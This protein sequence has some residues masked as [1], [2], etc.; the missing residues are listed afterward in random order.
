MYWTKMIS[1]LVA[2]ISAFAQSR[3]IEGIKGVASTNHVPEFTDTTVCQLESSPDQFDHK[4]IRVK[5]YF[6]FGLEEAGMYDPSCKQA[7][8]AN[9]D[10]RAVWVEFASGAEHERV[11]GYRPLIEDQELQKFH[12]VEEQRDGQ[13]L[14]AVVTGTFYAAK[15]AKDRKPGDVLFFAGYGHMNC[16]HLFV[17]SQVESVKTDYSPNL[18]YSA[19]WNTSEP[20]SCY[21]HETSIFPPM[22]RFVPG[23]RLQPKG[24]TVGDLIREKLRKSNWT[25]C[26]SEGSR[27]RDGWLGRTKFRTIRGRR[28]TFLPLRTIVRRELYLRQRSNPSKGNTST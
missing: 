26:S 15:T 17:V 9:H 25:R 8:S 20:H 21:S 14:S 12:D 6:S 2:T 1:C 18:D 11:T 19:F 16:C 24:V 13:M 23:S 4:E 27:T 7:S 22:R 28:V 3:N 10:V 5:A